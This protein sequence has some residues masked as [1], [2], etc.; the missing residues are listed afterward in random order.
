MIDT[1]QEE[2][3]DNDNI[4]TPL[5]P[6]PPGYDDIILNNLNQNNNNTNQNSSQNNDNN[7]NDNTNQNDDNNQN[8]DTNQNDDNESTNTTL[9]DYVP[10]REDDEL[11]NHIYID[12][13]TNSIRISLIRIE[14]NIR[15][16]KLLAFCAIVFNIVNAL[17]VYYNFFFYNNKI[18]NF[19]EIDSKYYNDTENKDLNNEYQKYKSTLIQYYTVCLILYLLQYYNYYHTQISLYYLENRR[20]YRCKKKI[21]NI[22]TISNQLIPLFSIVYLFKNY[23]R[24]MLSYEEVFLILLH[25]FNFVCDKVFNFVL[26][27]NIYLNL[28]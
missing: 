5:I 1:Y 13:M 8:N 27:I 23:N 22:L 26:N 12:D 25:G 4:A 6:P 14:N 11:I 10:V 7:Q 20:L 15:N 16:I 21:H 2:F 3:E 24:S 17:V 18:Y 9:P 28:Y 19:T